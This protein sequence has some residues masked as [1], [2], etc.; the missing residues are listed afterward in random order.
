MNGRELRNAN[1]LTAALTDISVE[2]LRNSKA[3][4]RVNV[5]QE[6]GSR[7]PKSRRDLCMENQEK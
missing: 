4:I 1:Q 5:L 3:D 7:D 6:A 2:E